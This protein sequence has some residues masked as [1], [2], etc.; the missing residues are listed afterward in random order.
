MI[1]IADLLGVGLYSPSEA[2]LYARVRPQL[3]ASWV[4]GTKGVRKSD[5]VF[6]PELGITDDKIVTFVDFVQA[7]AVRRLRNERHVSLQKIRE[8][9]D[10]AKSDFH[11]P[12]PFATE[13][14]RV[15]LFGPP[16][17]PDKQVV[18]ICFQKENEGETVE[19]KYYRYYQLTGKKHGNQ[20]IGEVVMTYARFLEF[21]PETQLARKFTSFKSDDGKVTMDPSVRF[22]E[23]FIEETGYTAHALFNAYQ[24]EASLQRAAEVYG[25]EPRYIQLAVDFFDYLNPSAAA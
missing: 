2:A 13:G 5:P 17:R 20:L 6:D 8:A 14:V 7:L 10:R 25:V 11:V 1:Q 19:E 3:M 23:P 9:Y 24:T 16:N 12:H 21:D 18:F 22:G 4:Y 15:G